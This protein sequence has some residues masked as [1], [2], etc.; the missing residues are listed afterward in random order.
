MRD[1]DGEGPTRT[2]IATREALPV[3]DLI[4]FVAAPDGSVV[5]DLKRKLP[6][7]GVWVSAHHGAVAEAVNKKAFARTLKAQVKA[8]DDLPDLVDTLLVRDALQALAMANKAGCVIAGS[9]KIEGG[10]KRGFT[11]LLH[12]SE[13]SE[14]GVIK[15]ERAVRS[16]SRVGLAIPSIR[17]FSGAELSLSLGR[18]HVIH[19][20]LVASAQSRQVLVKARAAE[21]YRRPDP[22]PTPPPG[23]PARESVGIRISTEDSDS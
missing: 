16:A 20:A 10:A 21:R 3:D 4:R 14:A 23:Q 19:A 7:R 12:A 22:A 17:L 9:A 8:A 18:E 2:C 11:A 13:A 1:P 6:G 5:P 15:L